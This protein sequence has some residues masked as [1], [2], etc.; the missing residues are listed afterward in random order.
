MQ[1][2][3]PEKVALHLL[4]VAATVLFLTANKRLPD[5]FF[6]QKNSLACLTY[7]FNLASQEI[8]AT[9][10]LVVLLLIPSKLRE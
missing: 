10:M 1:V 2:F 8:K 3:K 6:S 9:V 4:F 7:S 5:Q